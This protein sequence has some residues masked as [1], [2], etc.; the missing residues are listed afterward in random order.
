MTTNSN[1]ML[2][3]MNALLSKQKEL[4]AAVPHPLRIDSFERMKTAKE[5]IEAVLL[6]LN[7]TGH[8]PWRPNPL[9]LDTQ[10]A[11]LAAISSK[12][13]DL[14]NMEMRTMTPPKLTTDDINSRMLVSTFGGIEE[15]IE[16]FNSR[17]TLNK[18]DELNYEQRNIERFHS[19]EEITD[20]LFFFLEK[21]ALSGIS[22]REIEKEYYRKWDVNMKRYA[23]AKIGDFKW[24]KRHEG[25]L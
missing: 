19:I 3:N 2:F 13:Y 14:E 10:S 25:N 24:D 20:E 23:D 12:L 22:W 18:L 16:F 7:S 1:N 9:P 11:N 4:M 15:C 5:L 21:M 8:K 6:Y 17:E